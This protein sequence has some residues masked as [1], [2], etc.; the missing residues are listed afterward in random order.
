[1]REVSEAEFQ[2]VRAILALPEGPER[3][4][5]RL[6]RL[7]PSTFHVVR[8]RILAAGWIE[9][10]TVPHPGPC[11]LAGVEVVLAAP[12]LTE[13]EGVLRAWTADPE[14]SVLWA[15]V[16]SLFAVFFRRS[17]SGREAPGKAF[18]TEGEGVAIWADRRTG[19]IPVFL[20]YAGSWATF[21]GDGPPPRY[22]AGLDLASDP[23][24]IPAAA[25]TTLFPPQ[26]EDAADPRRA[27]SLGRSVP[28]SARRLLDRGIVRR[29]SFLLPANVPPLDGR[30]LGEVLF[31]SG[32]LR[33]GA[34][35]LSL[36]GQLTSECAV[37]PLLVASGQGA[38]MLLG[39]G[40]TDARSPGRHPV[41][42]ARSSVSAVVTAHLDR[43]HV[44]VEP[45]ESMEELVHHRYSIGPGPANR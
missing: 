7:A 13:R 11:G 43:V 35:A 20:D 36:L 28:R 24:P 40:Q 25:S 27:W 2:T 29:R 44:T 17:T 37:Y 21:G 33:H 38:L 31:V 19:S 16:Q 18:P 41:P 1:M 4:R 30:R 8:N 9:E 39:L 26:G 32:E 6:S 45:V 15:G 22:P 10:R 23:V 5:I 3:E 12:S 14:C 42:S 34:N